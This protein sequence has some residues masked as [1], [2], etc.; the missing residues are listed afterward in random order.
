[1]SQE[2]FPGRD[3]DRERPGDEVTLRKIENWFTFHA[4][5]TT[6]AE[7]YQLMREQARRFAAEIYSHVPPGPEREEA[8]KSLRSAVMW[9]N[10]GIACNES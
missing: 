8:I 7:R 5:N 1:M 10:A 4:A 6:Q 9:A 2:R 3:P